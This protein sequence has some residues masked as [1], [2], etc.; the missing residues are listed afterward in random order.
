[1]AAYE[2][3]ERDTEAALGA[4]ESNDIAAA[5]VFLSRALDA[6]PFFGPALLLLRNMRFHSPRSFGPADPGVDELLARA[7]CHTWLSPDLDPRAREGATA[8]REWCE[9][10]VGHAGRVCSPM[11]LWL[12]A[13]WLDMCGDEPDNSRSMR[14]FK[15]SADAGCSRAQNDLAAMI[16]RDAV[17]GC[18]VGDA[19]HLLE[20]AANAGHAGAMNRLG[21]LLLCR[22]DDVA[23][24]AEG[25]ALVARAAA[26]G[27]ANAQ[28]SWA[29]L[30]RQGAAALLHN[31]VQAPVESPEEL[32][33]ASAAQGD[34]VAMCELAH[35]AAYHGNLPRATMLLD[36]ARRRGL[37]SERECNKDEIISLLLEAG[38]KGCHEAA[39]AVVRMLEWASQ[40]V[41]QACEVS[42]VVR[43]RRYYVLRS[44]K[45][46]SDP[47]PEHTAQTL[48]RSRL[49]DEPGLRSLT[50][51]NLLLIN[52]DV[53]S[54]NTVVFVALDAHTHIGGLQGGFLKTIKTRTR[55]AFVHQSEIGENQAYWD[56]QLLWL[57]R[58]LRV[59]VAF[60]E[61]KPRMPSASK[62]SP[63]LNETVLAAVGPR[64]AA[65]YTWVAEDQRYSR[66]TSLVLDFVHNGSGLE[67]WVAQG[68]E[69]SVRDRPLPGRNASALPQL[70]AHEMTACNI[71]PRRWN[72]YVKA[73]Q[74][75]AQPSVA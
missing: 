40:D 10:V 4:L 41:R 37:D 58:Q 70:T 38:E 3:A 50:D 30:Q 63:H 12:A 55:T 42:E 62:R 8:S 73:R 15:E 6:A 68:R 46:G 5:R 17:V 34:G 57:T 31:G 43:S 60:E 29:R 16:L 11:A 65:V 9:Q 52:E 64:E 22:R 36:D 61:R 33:E 25:A 56:E 71:I 19:Q 26:S 7:R 44:C 23:L 32:L 67:V 51:A 1:M 14:A 18:S 27:H 20:M 54:G 45:R 13:L 39:P 75:T 49:Y 59:P 66:A 28:R 53:V 24:R 48:S 47:S 2:T 69:P 21:V 72:Y 35:I 74:S